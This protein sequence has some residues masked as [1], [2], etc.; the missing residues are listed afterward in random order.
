MYG[1]AHTG[2]E[3]TAA[4]LTSLLKSLALAGTP[5][6]CAEA[7]IER[8]NSLR[9]ALIFAVLGSTA[10]LRS[11]PVSTA[12][13]LPP[14]YREAQPGREQTYGEAQP[15]ATATVPGSTSEQGSRFMG[16]PG[17]TQGLPYREAQRGAGA[18]YREAQVGARD[19][20]LASE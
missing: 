15:D 7:R 10:D 3:L 5:R 18:P 13:T 20:F 6:I 17:Y 14:L 2:H 4:V 19:A 9:W 1:E 11:V 12:P 16:R 8:G